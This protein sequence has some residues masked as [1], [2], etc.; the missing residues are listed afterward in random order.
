[1]Y[2]PYMSPGFDLIP[3]GFWRRLIAALIDLVLVFF[4]GVVLALILSPLLLSVP[5]RWQPIFSSPQQSLVVVG[6]YLVVGWVYSASL[7]SSE[8]QATIGKNTVGIMVCDLSGGRIGFWQA[9]LRYLGKLL[10]ILT[11][12]IGFLI[13]LRHP[14]R[15]TLHDRLTGTLV[16]LNLDSP[17]IGPA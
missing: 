3:A 10:S 6:A 15:Q 2:C 17:L 7:E 1:M 11:L 14:R 12:G 8:G 5:A 4:A 16:V 13:M 9:S